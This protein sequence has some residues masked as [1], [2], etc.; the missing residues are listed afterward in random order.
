[1]NEEVQQSD[2]LELAF[3]TRI[4]IFYRPTSL[5]KSSSAERVDD[6]RWERAGGA[7]V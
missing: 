5:L 3:R 2:R 4:K 7:K 1:V 6:L